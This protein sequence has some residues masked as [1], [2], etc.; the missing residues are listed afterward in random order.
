MKGFHILESRQ[1]SRST[2]RIKWMMMGAL[3]GR[4]ETGSETEQV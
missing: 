3:T 2:E 4:S 1:K